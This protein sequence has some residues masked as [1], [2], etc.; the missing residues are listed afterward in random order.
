[1]P[2]TYPARELNGILIAGFVAV[3]L[4]KATYPTELVPKLQAMDYRIDV[5]ARKVQES[6]DALMDDVLKTLE[7]RV[8]VLLDM[9][10]NQRW[11]LFIGVITETD[12]L[13]HFFMDAIDDPGHKYHSAF[14]EFYQRVDNFLG[15]I[16]DRLGNETLLVMSDHGFTQIKQQVYLNRWLMDNGYLKLKENARSIEDIADGSQAFALDPGRIYVNAKGRYPNGSVN[17][18]D[19]NRILGEIKQGL[20][21]ITVERYACSQSSLRTRRIIRRALSGGGARPMRAVDLRF[22]PE[23]RGPQAATNGS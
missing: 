8:A 5:D 9:F 22:R 12:R 15:Q 16:A 2:S 21:E 11:D 14:R 20:S 17:A 23:G 6:H 13:Q 4:N 1:M 10:D 7:R 19:F 18:A 3:D